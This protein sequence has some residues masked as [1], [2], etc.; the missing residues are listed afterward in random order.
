MFKAHIK[1]IVLEE[2]SKKSLSGYDLMKS[3]GEIGKKPSPGYI[4]PMLN[5]LKKK[6]FVS[7][8]SDERRKVYSITQSGKKFLRSLKI[9]RKSMFKKMIEIWEPIANKKE[10]ENLKRLGLGGSKGSPTLQEIGLIKRLHKSIFLV[11]ENGNKKQKDEIKN[12]LKETIERL[13]K[14]K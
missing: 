3:I 5:D 12:I 14:I 8:K 7:V 9:K 6:G 4:Y 11:Y 13:G 1:L 2:L 10:L